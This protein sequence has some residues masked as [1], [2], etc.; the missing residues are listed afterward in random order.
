MQQPYPPIWVAG[1][2]DAA[3]RRAAIAGDGWYPYLFTVNRIRR[4]NASVREMAEH[5]GRD[6]SGFNWG[7]EPAHRD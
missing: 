4:S 3:I 1:R 7:F 2:S 5:S 6:L